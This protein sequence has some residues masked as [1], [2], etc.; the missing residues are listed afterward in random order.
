MTLYWCSLVVERSGWQL[1]TELTKLY[2]WLLHTSGCHL[3]TFTVLILIHLMNDGM[4]NIFIVSQIL[5]GA[6]TKCVS[7]NDCIVLFNAFTEKFV[8]PIVQILHTTTLVMCWMGWRPL[9]S[10]LSVGEMAPRQFSEALIHLGHESDWH[11]K[12]HV[13]STVQIEAFGQGT[14]AILVTVAW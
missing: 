5:C 10:W 3:S 13:R 9:R 6:G 12:K 7:Q 2:G 14:N 11:L 4:F 8:Y 1:E